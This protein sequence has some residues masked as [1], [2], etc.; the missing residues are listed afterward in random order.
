M[1]CGGQD[2]FKKIL[3]HFI[4]FKD[5]YELSTKL[6]ECSGYFSQCEAAFIR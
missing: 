4:N 1:E 6:F 5:G 3:K 2:C